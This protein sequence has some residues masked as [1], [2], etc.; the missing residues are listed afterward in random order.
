MPH[1]QEHFELEQQIPNT[2]TTVAVDFLRKSVQSMC[3]ALQNCVQNAG[4]CVEI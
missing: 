2:F 4:A 3:S 1:S